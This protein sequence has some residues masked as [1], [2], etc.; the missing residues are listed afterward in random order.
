MKMEFDVAISNNKN[1]QGKTIINDKR[2]S[3]FL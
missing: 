3:S 1:Q 2:S